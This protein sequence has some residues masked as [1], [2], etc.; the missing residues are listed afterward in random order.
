MA[1]E[2]LIVPAPLSLFL[3]M[4]FARY[5]RGMGT[6]GISYESYAQLIINL[7]EAEEQEQHLI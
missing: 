7:S 4:F 1:T 5:Y 6:S 3:N 2:G